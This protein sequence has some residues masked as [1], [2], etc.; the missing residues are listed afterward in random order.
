MIDLSDV[1]SIMEKCCHL[2]GQKNGLSGFYLCS[3][4]SSSLIRPAPTRLDQGKKESCQY[5]SKACDQIGLLFM[6][7]I[8][9]QNVR[10]LTLSASI[11][12]RSVRRG[13]TSLGPGQRR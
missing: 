5:D 12:F 13:M 6:R 1:E 7:D 2:V 10:P 9:A 8:N 3:A 4:I 11:L